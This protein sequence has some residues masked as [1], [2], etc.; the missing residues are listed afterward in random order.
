MTKKDNDLGAIPEEVW[1]RLYAVAAK[2]EDMAPWKW[3]EEADVF[4]VWPHGR[5]TSAFVSVMG[6]LG[7][8]RAVAV[9]AG[10]REWHQFLDIQDGPDIEENATSI[11]DVLH[12]H[13]AFG[14]AADLEPQDKRLMRQLGLKFA[15]RALRP[16]F[17]DY[18]PGY[19]PWILEAEE[20]ARL[21]AE[22]LEQLLVMAPRVKEDRALLH[23][24]N[25]THGVLVRSQSAPGGA[26]KEQV[27]VFPPPTNSF[28]LMMPQGLL[29]QVM[30]LP[31][32]RLCVE[33]DVFPLFVSVG[34]RGRRPRY[35]YTVM[36]V[37]AESL[38]ILGTETVLVETTLESMWATLP[39]KLLDMM[40]KNGVRPAM[41][42]VRA[43]WLYMA[44]NGLCDAL[45]WE[46]HLTGQL[47]ALDAARKD[48]E[49]FFAQ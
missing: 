40:V 18:R 39:E 8:Y 31:E 9:Y 41:L 11:L 33:V 25:R 47:P 1:Q 10:P 6:M 13:A 26:W 28:R 20:E 29:D 34:E 49:Q 32:A 35:P 37:D 24:D 16:Y 48:M 21:L 45:E 36:A 19:H 12:I 43:P 46:V 38:F 22:A 30:A 15:P 23:A 27:H 7:E 4:G 3:M 42:A 44:L 5:E 2:V 14:R 17:R